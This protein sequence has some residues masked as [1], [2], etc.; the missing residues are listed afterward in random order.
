MMLGA[1]MTQVISAMFVPAD[2]AP[3]DRLLRHA[4][5]YLAKHPNEAKAHATLA[6]IHHYA[7]QTTRDRIGAFE[8][9]P[10]DGGKDALPVVTDFVSDK[11]PGRPLSEK[12]MVRHAA[13]ALEEYDEAL[14]LDPSLSYCWLSKAY[15]METFAKYRDSTLFVD[16][17]I[18]GKP[19]KEED[20]PASLRGITKQRIWDAF[21]KAFEANLPELLKLKDHQLDEVVAVEAA[22]NVISL[23][24][25][26]ENTLSAT[27]RKT[28][29]RAR[30]AVAR[31]K[32]LPM[33]PITPI[34]FALQ[35]AAHLSDL[36]APDTVVDFDLRGWGFRERWSW[37]K[38]ELGMLVWDP[39]QKGHITSAHQLFGGYSFQIFWDH[40]YDAL[41][42]LDDNGDGMLSGV[43][44]AGISA[45]FDRNGNGKSDPGEVVPL[46]DMGVK[47]VA[48]TATGQDGAHLMNPQGIVFKNGHVLPTWDWMV[49]PV[50]SERLAGK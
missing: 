11:R 24:N 5:A 7:L 34:V 21:A 23:A 22:R 1:G 25:G 43:E 41:A 18:F 29:Q 48:V 33:G 36:L 14:R 8:P 26:K 19:W 42:A 50:P 3:V 28:L 35:P 6:R 40:G 49:E 39:L 44:L 2:S 45:W 38:P 16:N 47:E 10:E 32:K 12:A 13:Q 20:L 9:T 31:Y 37:V 17:S 15:V 27:D 46:E 30:L 4:E